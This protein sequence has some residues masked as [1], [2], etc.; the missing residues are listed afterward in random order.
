MLRLSPA[1]R[2]DFMFSV[3]TRK[4]FLLFLFFVAVMTLVGCAA[5]NKAF[6]D[7]QYGLSDTLVQGD[8]RNVSNGM[9]ML[10]SNIFPEFKSFGSV[11]GCGILS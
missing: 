2:K 8:I 4:G 7:Y 5:V 9:V 3:Y 6:E 1:S 11:V 10:L